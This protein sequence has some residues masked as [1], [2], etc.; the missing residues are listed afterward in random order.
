[1]RYGIKTS[2][3]YT[4]WADMLDVW[5][6]AD[7]M[8]VFHSAWNFDHFYPIN[9]PDTTGPCMECWVTLSALAQATERIR[10]GAMVTGTVYRHPAV[11]A[12]MISTLDIVSKGRL[13]VGLG[14]G[15]SEEECQ[16]Y[17]IGLGPLKQRFDRFDEVCEIIVSMLSNEV[18]NFSGD[19]FTL[20][21]ARN[22]PGPVQ[23]PYPPI[24]I[25]GNGEKRTLPN[26]ARYAQHWN[27]AGFDLDGF[28]AKR[29]VLRGICRDIGR[30]PD[31]ILTSIHQVAD[32]EKLGELEEACHKFKE[33][34]LG[35]MIFYLPPPHRAASLEPLAAIAERVG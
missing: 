21:D 5:Q 23:Q 15:W 29:E 14:A 18:T 1:M 26:V 9:V 8:P 24:C 35:L 30:N 4:E 13:E 32:P 20:T 3:Q 33:A 7:Q 11:L 22:N 27:Y 12:N 28:V 19:Y 31:H 17:G 25:G 34:G 10:I 16:A 2:P 6:A